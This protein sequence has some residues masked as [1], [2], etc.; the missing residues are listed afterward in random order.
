MAAKLNT[1]FLLL[2]V[3]IVGAI[4]ITVGAI[5][6]FAL[7]D[8]P[9]RNIARAED[10]IA[11]GDYKAAKLQFERAWGKQPTDLDI[12]ERFEDVL[13]N[14][15]PIT[16]DLAN[17]YYQQ[18]L[19]IKTQRI[20][21]RPNDVDFHLDLLNEAYRNARITQ[22][23]GW[24]DQLRDAGERASETLSSEDVPQLKFYE[25]V[26]KSS[27]LTFLTRDEI[28]ETERDFIEYVRSHPE[29]ARAGNALVLMLLIQA[30]TAHRDRLASETTEKLLKADSVLEMINTAAPDHPETAL[31]NCRRLL[32]RALVNPASVTPEDRI[33]AATKLIAAMSDDEEPHLVAEVAGLL[34]RMA[35]PEGAR[36][37]AEMLEKTVARRPNDLFSRWLLTS[38]LMDTGR[39][40]EAATHAEVILASKELPVSF[41]ATHRFDLQRQAAMALFHVESEKLTDAKVTDITDTLAGAQA[42]R[43]R[44]AALCADDDIR[45]IECDAWLAF[46]RRDYHEAAAKFNEVLVQKPAPGVRVLWGSAICMRETGSTGKALETMQRALELAGNSLPI[47]LDTARLELAV[48]RNTEAM[49]HL[50]R[51]L[52]VEPQNQDAAYLMGQVRLS[53]GATD[54]Q[55]PT[56]AL[57]E[58][59]RRI[60]RTGNLDGARAIL[61]KAYEE[62][63][64]NWPLV[65]ALTEV[66][67]LRGET[68]AAVARLEDL[69]GR[70]PDNPEVLS[71]LMFARGD[72]PVERIDRVMQLRYPGDETRQVVASYV[73]MRANA[74]AQR[75]AAERFKTSSMQSDAEKALAIAAELDAAADQRAATAKQLNASSLEFLDQQFLDALNADDMAAARK[76]AEQARTSNADQARG[77]TFEARLRLHEKNIEA[78]VVTLN[79]AAKAKPY[80]PW[81]WRTLGAVYQRLGNMVDAE[82]SYQKALDL[83]PNDLLT[84]VSFCDFLNTTGQLRKSLVMMRAASSRFSAEPAFRERWLKLEAEAGDPYR[85]IIERR[86]LYAI[87]PKD[88]LNAIRLASLLG[89]TMPG[90]QAI[91][92]DNGAARY[93]ERAFATLPAETKKSMLDTVQASWRAE[94]EGIFSAMEEKGNDSDIG[95][96]YARAAYLRDIGQPA[97]ARA[98]MEAFLN[99]RVGE[100]KAT[101]LMYVALAN[102][103][104]SMQDRDTAREWLERGRES[105]SDT[106]R[107]IDLALAALA[108]EEGDHAKA[109]EHFKRVEEAINNRNLQIQMLQAEVNLGRSADARRRLK[110]MRAEYGNSHELELLEAAALGAEAVALA[111]AGK[112]AEAAEARAAERRAIDRATA[113]APTDPWPHVAKARSILKEFNTTTPPRYGLLDDA[114][115]SVS[116]ATELNADFDPALRLRAELLLSRKSPDFAGAL[117]ELRRSLALN[118]RDDMLRS[119]IID[120]YVRA[121]QL[122]RAIELVD[123]AA[124]LRPDSRTWLLRKGELYSQAKR[125]EEAAAAYWTAFE[126]SQQAFDL[127]MWGVEKLSGNPDQAALQAVVRELSARQA[128]VQANPGL[129][130]VQALTF[131]TVGRWDE[132]LQYAR[133]SFAAYQKYAVERNQPDIMET[134]HR[135][136]YQLFEGRPVAE[137]ERFVFDVTNQSPSFVDLYWVGKAWMYRDPDGSSR[138]VDLFQQAID[139]AGDQQPV[140]LVELYLRLGQANYRLGQIPAAAA[141]YEKAIALDPENAAALNDLAYIYIDELDEPEKGIPYVKRA[142]AIDPLNVNFLDTLG[143]AYLRLGR[144]EE[145]AANIEKSIDMKA[146]AGNH[147]HMAELRIAQD[148][149]PEARRLLETAQR[150]NPDPVTSAEITR[151]LDDI[152]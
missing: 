113:M 102:L 28:A 8:D 133:Q 103:L 41:L 12:M 55:D 101:S 137:M 39:I 66:D 77:L 53:E 144:L 141:A 128:M 17:E 50:T 80:D 78:A 84:L 107:E 89:S 74:E 38:L 95:V 26:A 22:S 42:A 87:D 14:V 122:N 97:A 146:L 73:A 135:N 151:L 7:R 145:A 130:D 123:E 51:A 25:L 20:V 23:R 54:I 131:K 99:A 148:R 69:A 46:A 72:N 34:P 132:A 49:G 30:E 117:A 65:N 61:I 149:I 82:R 120:L 140:V 118:P 93:T 48:G 111:E 31:A 5:A 59:S 126:Q 152:N 19:L 56:V 147:L 40:P 106:E 104:N 58:E 27:L 47:L 68:D 86:R 4:A 83:R 11:R 88:R 116:K 100:G 139:R 75:D 18:Y 110:A 6:Y 15:T 36:M 129:Q 109:L 32:T 134:W 16:A 13:N 60:A 115:L 136:L 142:L 125:H 127:A 63:P 79:D 52:E 29:D 9:S 2:L 108:I 37:T 112:S 21:A 143:V 3:T 44:L 35:G 138:A 45:V 1:K 90:R 98:H 24:W 85:A 91:V 64:D 62:N 10:A 121:N 94:A 105:Q 119:G 114:L 67:M 33:D 92:D 150:L 43:D 81:V 71:L 76:I 70:F 124:A 96:A 57:I